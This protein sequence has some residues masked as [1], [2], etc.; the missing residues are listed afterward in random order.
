MN[1]PTQEL[2]LTNRHATIAEQMLK[3]HQVLKAQREGF[4]DNH[5]SQIVTKQGRFHMARSY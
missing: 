2:M 3:E 1:K 5:V 4:D